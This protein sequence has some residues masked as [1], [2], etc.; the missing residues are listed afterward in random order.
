MFPD[1]LLRPAAVKQSQV[2]VTK[3]SYHL[4]LWF[5]IL[6]A[7]ENHRGRFK[8][9]WHPTPTRPAGSEVLG[10]EF[11]EW[12]CAAFRAP[13]VTPGVARAE[14]LNHCQLRHFRS[15]WIRE[16]AGGTCSQ[17]AHG[18]VLEVP[19]TSSLMLTRWARTCL[20]PAQNCACPGLNLMLHSVLSAISRKTHA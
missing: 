10:V 14:H 20:S 7:Q 18:T 6:A 9:Q 3:G 19:L 11:L 15:L 13:Q 4:A 17:L 1:S 5:R 16:R 12:A 2:S 8:N